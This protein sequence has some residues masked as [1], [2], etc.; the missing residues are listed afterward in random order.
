MLD[1]LKL[2]FIFVVPDRRAGRSTVIRHHKGFAN[3]FAARRSGL[4]PLA[5]GNGNIDALADAG[6]DFDCDDN[7]T[8]DEEKEEEEQTN[9]QVGCFK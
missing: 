2:F 5:K 1:N 8:S 4:G 3:D 7:E 9:K 6:G